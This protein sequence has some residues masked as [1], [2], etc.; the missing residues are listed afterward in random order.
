MTSLFPGALLARPAAIDQQ[1]T[2]ELVARVLPTQL[3]SGGS[4]AEKQELSETLDVFVTESGLPLRVSRV[5]R[6]GSITLSETI[7]ILALNVPVSVSAPPAASTIS[8]AQAKRLG[9]ES[10]GEAGGVGVPLAITL[11]GA[12]PL[13]IGDADG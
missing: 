3:L 4:Q 10:A 8:A 2:T 9:G 7:D 13:A 1:R 5:E 6:L 11:V 12:V